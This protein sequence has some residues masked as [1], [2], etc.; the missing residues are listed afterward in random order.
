MTPE[1]WGSYV[2]GLIDLSPRA[3]RKRFRQSIKDEWGCCAY[4]GKNH[5]HLTIDHVKPR[6]HGGSSMRSNLVPACVECNSTK[7]SSNWREWYKNQDFFCAKKATRIEIWIR[8]QIPEEWDLWSKIG[9]TLNDQKSRVDSRT[10]IYAS[11]NCFRDPES[12]SRRV[13]SGITRLL[14]G[15]ISAEAVLHC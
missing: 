14:G 2:F 6:T 7:G 1:H 15:S 3:A 4:C 13:A 5:V 11:S 8:P 12:K 10:T 9:G